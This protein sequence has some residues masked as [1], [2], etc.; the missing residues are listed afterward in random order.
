MTAHLL[1][2]S[3]GP[4]QEFIRAARRTRDL[5]FGSYL[6]S[7]VSKA[8]AKAVHSRG[9]KLIFPAP[10]D[11]ADLEPKSQFNVANVIVVEVAGGDPQLLAREA[12][13]AAQARWRSFADDAFRNCQD[14]IRRG[15]W[16]DQVDDVLEFYAAWIPY[17][18]QNYQADRTAL[19]RLL[20][21]RK[22]CRDFR[23][24]KGRAGIA[25]SSLDGLR[26]SV[27]PSATGRSEAQR[28][29]LRL[30][31]GEELDVVG[32]VK[33][34]ASADLAP[35]YPSVERVAADP[36][37]RRASKS[38]NFEA[39][40]RACRDLGNEIVHE[41]ATS[42]PYGH[43]QYADFPFDGTPVFRSRH[44][45][46]REETALPENA[47]QPLVQI[48]EKLTREFDEPNPYLGVLVADGDQIGQ[49]LSQLGS[50][51]EHQEFSRAL[52]GF[53]EKAR[54][55]V[56]ADSGVLVYSGGDDVLAFVPVDRCLPCARALY[57]RFRDTLAG[58]SVKTGQALSLSVGV[59][60][61]HFMEPLEDLLEYG[62]SAEQHA[63]RPSPEDRGQQ[64][65]DGLAIHLVKRGGAPLA[66]RAN[67][68]E[69]L[70]E[71]LIRLTELTRTRAISAT[72]AYDLY[73]IA[74]MYDSW[75]GHTVRD[76]I[77]AD[78]VSV[79]QGKKPRGASR[80]D[81]LIN[82][83]RHDVTDAAALNRLAHQLVIAKVLAAVST[84]P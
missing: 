40:K 18:G 6:L 15:I 53:A 32:V 70:D 52:A 11:D 79:L 17:S 54:T 26:E 20:A 2:F 47:L 50:P 24:A 41:I 33:R 67:W 61:G 14:I 76:A 4:V 1:A 42:E 25:K 10:L 27:L 78:V 22:R 64:P 31:K 46:F 56:H 74:K 36:W 3:V 21:A 66:V 5:W 62:R 34:I 77:Q 75:P 38:S 12:K 80:I 19:M 8:A 51:Q 55:I 44:R 71:R 58:W 9:G 45:E 7:E 60:I 39:L 59:A 84:S 57:D 29:R 28:R 13:D 82:L 37:L 81:E 83:V 30:Q 49:A 69:N 68:S 63:K 65:R 43:P 35:R 23:P 16:N 73:Q 48:L 72:I